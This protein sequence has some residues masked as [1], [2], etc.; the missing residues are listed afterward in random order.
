MNQHAAT[1]HTGRVEIPIEGMT[2]ASC[3]NRIE[4]FLRKVDGVDEV[5]VNL[6]TERATIMYQPERVDLDALGQAVRA[7][8]Y[9][10]R[11]D[12]VGRP[13]GSVVGSA[14]AT[15]TIS[16]SERPSV[17]GHAAEHVERRV[18]D[19]RRRFVVAAVLTVPLLLGLAA[20]TVA[21][22]LPAWL[23]DPWLQLVLATP[24]QLY[25]GWPFTRGALRAARHR[26]ATMDTLVAIGTWAA[27]GTSVVALAAWASAGSPG[28]SMATPDAPVLWFDTAGVIITLILLG[29][30]L[31]ARAR[32][33]TSDAIR[34]LVR[35]A[36][37]VARLIRDDAEIELPVE[38]VVPGD[39]LIVRPG[40]RIPVDGTVTAG[41]S[42]VDESML[43]GESMPVAR[44]VGD[45]V[46][47]GSLNGSGS[48]R[49]EARR[50]G[51][52]TVLAHIVALVQEAQGSKPPIQ[53][54][55][56]R[57]TG[58]FVPLIL[59]VAAATFGAWLVLGPSPSFEMAL[60]NAVAV[61]IVACPCA[62]GLAT[63]TSVMVGTGRAAE[64][65]VLFRNGAALEH[66]GATRTMVLD[67]TGTLTRG[68]ARVTEVETVPGALPASEVVRLVAGAE[69]G[70]EHPLGQ[71]VV[72]H[73]RET[74]RLVVPTAE[75]FR[76]VMGEGVAA[77]VEGRD[78]LVGRAAWLAEQGVATEP[79]EAIADRLAADGRTAVLVA[80]DGR[81]A[82]VMGVA[83]TLRAE[84][85]ATVAR[86]RTM[87][88]EPVMLTGDQEAT[89]LAI[90]GQAGITR[91]LADVRPDEKQA[92]VRRLQ[93]S[94]GP[95]T[96][97]GDGVNDAPALAAADVGIALGTGTDVAVQSASVTLMRPD[98][99]GLVAAIDV[100][101][102]TMR[103]IRQNLFWAFAYNVA[104]VPL[105]AGVL[106]PVTGALLD[107]MLAAAAMAL[108]SVTVVGNALRLR[109]WHA[110]DAPRAAGG[111]G[112]PTGEPALSPP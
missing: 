48:F 73:A 62:L 57:V 82:A 40:E 91:A 10:P 37:P 22:F 64:H 23:A 67:K 20:M 77:T 71:A 69:S 49:F 7:A 75:A 108:S 14:V 4:R 66:L 96:M 52:D 105:A 19:T 43:T 98:L 2:C 3:V 34:H 53:R 63:P 33:H 8:G 58:R 61:L 102:A 84:A 32:A 38:R 99:W 13:V 95:V 79:L 26:E 94:Q 35:L 80:V 65:G 68:D 17:A 28:M 88:V 93:A 101:R 103:N 6:A 31:E 36:P 100:S 9:D 27:Y 104:L 97:V 59:L 41:S 47:A 55:A 81:A 42:W 92:H 21:P 54:L 111:H 1:T 25:S 16:T 24:V 90:A 45:A 12:L 78:V 85:R 76:A 70:S 74:L 87:G 5:T 56:D 11:L 51:R 44:G 60:A 18:A 112:A 39:V 83:D 50:V 110:P 107:P 29:R 86:L 109:G 46:V 15:S 106:Y 72:R 30:L 89:A